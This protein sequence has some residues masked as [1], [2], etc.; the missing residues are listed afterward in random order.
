MTMAERMLYL[1]AELREAL[2]GIAWRTGPPEETDTHHALRDYVRRY[3]RPWHW[4][5][6]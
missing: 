3:E 5:G 1:P 6:V 4:E 2:R